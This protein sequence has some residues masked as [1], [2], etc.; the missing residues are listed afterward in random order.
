MKTLK[1]ILAALLLAGCQNHQMTADAVVTMLKWEIKNTT[2]FKPDQKLMIEKHLIKP[3]KER[4]VSDVDSTKAFH[5]WT[6]YE[7]SPGAE[8]CRV[9]F[10]DEDEKRYGLGIKM[11]GRAYYWANYG[12]FIKTLKGM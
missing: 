10:Y 12:N 5:L 11:N 3:K 2:E 4:Y 6:V 9:I 1:V 7:E 8:K